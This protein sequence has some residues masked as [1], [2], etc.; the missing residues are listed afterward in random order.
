MHLEMCRGKLIM[1]VVVLSTP[2]SPSYF[3]IET[4]GTYVH[5]THFHF[6]ELKDRHLLV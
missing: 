2:L 6:L 3:V 4:L 5:M 1:S